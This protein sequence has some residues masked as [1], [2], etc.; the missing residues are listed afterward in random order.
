VELLVGPAASTTNVEDD[1]DGGPL[2]VLP[3]GSVVSTIDVEE[4]VDGGPWGKL[5]AGPVAS[6]T[7]VE[8]DMVSI[9]LYV[10]ILIGSCKVKHG[11]Q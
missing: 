3:M 2:G 7:K 1:I 9:P 5:P 10:Q 8:D 6:T 4:D 11:K